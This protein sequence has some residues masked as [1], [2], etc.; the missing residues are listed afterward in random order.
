MTNIQQP[1]DNPQNTRN[2]VVLD[3]AI[4]TVLAVFFSRGYAAG[5]K[6]ARAGA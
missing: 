1:A 5:L 4:L 6:A 3:E 2:D